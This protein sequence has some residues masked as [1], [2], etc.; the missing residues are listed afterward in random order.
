MAEAPAV[1]ANCQLREA[2]QQQSSLLYEEKDVY[3]LPFAQHPTAVDCCFLDDAPCRWS[4]QEAKT[5]DH[6]TLSCQSLARSR[7]FSPA[8]IVLLQLQHSEREHSELVPQNV[9]YAVNRAASA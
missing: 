7:A 4:N 8:A 2:S 6:T 1:S 9:S 3:A 5:L